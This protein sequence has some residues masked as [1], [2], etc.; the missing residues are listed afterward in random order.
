MLLCPAVR[1][2]VDRPGGGVPEAQRSVLFPK[3]QQAGLRPFEDVRPLWVNVRKL[4]QPAAH[5]LDRAYLNYEYWDSARQTHQ[6]PLV[7]SLARARAPAA[8][9]CTPR[10]S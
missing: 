6:V 7:I 9:W 2:D 4:A 3:L 10:V 8:R 1:A 5:C